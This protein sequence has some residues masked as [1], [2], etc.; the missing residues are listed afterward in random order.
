MQTLQV[1]LVSGGYTDSTEVSLQNHAIKI[2]VGTILQLTI[3]YKLSQFSKVPNSAHILMVWRSIMPTFF[4]TRWRFTLVAA[5]WS[6]GMVASFQH[7]D[8]N[9]DLQ[10]LTMSSLSP[11]VGIV[12]ITTSPKSCL[13]IHSQSLGSH[14]ATLKWREANTQQLQFPNHLLNVPQCLEYSF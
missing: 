9:C 10:R 11:V 2:F 4:A 3:K 8:L 1:L 5:N 12:I 13:G 14:L 6:G 7:Q